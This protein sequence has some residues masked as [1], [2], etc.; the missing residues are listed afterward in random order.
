MKRLRQPKRARA[1]EFAAVVRKPFDIDDFVS[2]LNKAV[3]TAA[4]RRVSDAETAARVSNLRERLIG[5]GA[6]DLTTSSRR[7]WATFHGAGE[8]LMQIY[9]WERLSL[10]LVGRYSADGSRLE[11]LGQF[12]DLGAAIAVALPP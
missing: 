11:P 10:Y 4:A 3:R 9:W 1:A 2:T 8:E 5:A 7:V 12:A 6:R